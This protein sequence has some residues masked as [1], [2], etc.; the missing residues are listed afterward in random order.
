MLFAA[1]EYTEELMSVSKG[2]T[3]SSH[4]LEERGNRKCHLL[5]YPTTKIPTIGNRGVLLDYRGE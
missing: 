4:A 5:L 3:V 2:V 1:V